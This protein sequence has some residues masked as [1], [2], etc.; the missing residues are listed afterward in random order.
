MDA[1]WCEG[2][3]FRYND[4]KAP[5]IEGIDLKIGR[6]ELVLLMGRSGCG[7]TTLLKLLK[8]EIAPFGELSGNISLLG[9]KAESPQPMVGYAAQLPEESFVSDRVYGEIMFAPENAGLSA[10]K[11]RRAAAETITRF[12]LGKLLDR[13]LDELS[14]GE[15]SW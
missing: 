4:A 5:A 14:G 7:K 2:L 9:K 8:P 13:K 15:N 6:G 1:V 12:G 11:V 10:E 3:T